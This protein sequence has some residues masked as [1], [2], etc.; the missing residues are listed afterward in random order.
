MSDNFKCIY[1]ILKTLEKAM[2]YPSF[3]FEVI[4]NQQLGISKER[5]NAYIEM[6]NDSGYVKGVIIKKYIG[7]EKI[8]DISDMRIT[9]KGLEYLTENSIMQKLY[10]VAKGIKEITPGM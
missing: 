4:S 7:G 5:W 9:L 6:L 2:D 1:T 8:I 10:N 3:D